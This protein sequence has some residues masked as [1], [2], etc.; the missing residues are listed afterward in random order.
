[1]RRLL[2]L[3]IICFLLTG[4]VSAAEVMQA[5][6]D[7]FGVSDLEKGLPDE[8]SE[9][10]EDLSPMEQIS[11]RDGFRG[12]MESIRDK[13]NGILKTAA[14]L[15][16][17]LLGIVTICRL[18]EEGKGESVT[19]AAAMA[20]S[21]GVIACCASNLHGMIGLGQRTMEEISTFSKLLLPVMAS[22]ASAAGAAASAG[23]LYAV[24]AVSSNVLI[25]FSQGVLL[26]V[27][28]GYLALALA[29][30]AVQEER[31]RKLRELLGWCIRQGLR[32]GMYLFTGFLTVTGILS[33]TADAAALKAAKLTMSG[34]IPVVGGILSDAAQTV[35]T[36]AGLLKNAV[37][38]YGMLAVAAIFLLPFLRMGVQFLAFKITA[39]LGSILGSRLCGLLDAI[40]EAMGFLLAMTASSA[41]M[42]LLSCCCLMQVGS[43]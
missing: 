14:A 2:I 1:M 31:L 25:S 27:V 4:T 21:L 22:A 10:L 11:L 40:S 38:T 9:A 24:T 15:M 29:D 6:A 41:F 8:A 16:L 17:Q 33:G 42:V 12:I 34:M 7:L 5:Q 30:S 26:P 35:L 3:G 19:H 43:L 13:S 18:A 20:G 36:G 32:I 39:A 28:Y 37:G 23:G